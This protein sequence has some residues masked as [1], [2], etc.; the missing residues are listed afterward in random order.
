L[1][2]DVD[3]FYGCPL[4]L[5]AFLAHLKSSVGLVLELWNWYK[6]T[7]HALKVTVFRNEWLLAHQPHAGKLFFDWR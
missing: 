2:R 4:Q 7:V 5:L 6:G 1:A 3:V